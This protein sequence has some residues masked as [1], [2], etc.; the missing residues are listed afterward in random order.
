VFFVGRYERVEHEAGPETAL[1][2]DG[3]IVA[4]VFLV[5]TGFDLFI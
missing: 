1:R 5:L 3:A 2:I 4:A